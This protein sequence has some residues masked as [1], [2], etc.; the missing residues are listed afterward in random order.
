MTSPTAHLTWLLLP[1]LV[2]ADMPKTGVSIDSQLLN[3][4]LDVPLDFKHDLQH[5]FMTLKHALLE[6][7]PSKAVYGEILTTLNNLKKREEFYVV[8]ATISS[9]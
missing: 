8:L 7:K 4:D 9:P 3:T 2:L 1:L 5:V 6:A